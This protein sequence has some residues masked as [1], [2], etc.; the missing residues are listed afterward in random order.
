[1]K[2]PYEFAPDIRHPLYLIRRSILKHIGPL[3]PRLTGKMLDF[4]CGSKPYQSIF[5]V[6]EYIGI[7]YENPGHSHANE[8]IDVFYDG[9]K[10][11]FP[12]ATFDS[13]LATEVFEHVFY[14]EDTLKEIH[15]VMKPG[16]HLL[17]SAPF[18]FMEHE[19][20]HD[21]ARYSSFGMR[22]LLERNGFKVEVLEKTSNYVDVLGQMGLYYLNNTF[23][24][25][26]RNIPL[27]GKSL[28]VGG[29]MLM[30]ILTLF[31]SRILPKRDD[32]YLGL[33][34]LAQKPKV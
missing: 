24:G 5:E 14:L 27:I 21:F 23:V 32:W 4:G 12:D 31:M 2:I 18:V 17:L 9:K 11:P 15:R 22:A 1:M 28:R 33:V 8:H 20:P 7:D 16:G 25:Y 6:D 26:L 34:V 30:N 29:I 19:I 3:A 10:I 13:V